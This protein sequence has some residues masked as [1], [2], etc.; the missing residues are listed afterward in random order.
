M[1]KTGDNQTGLRFGSGTSNCLPARFTP[2]LGAWEVPSTR[3][4]RNVPAPSFSK[5]GSMGLRTNFFSLNWECARGRA[6]AV[7]H[8]HRARFDAPSRMTGGYSSAA[9]GSINFAYNPLDEGD[10]HAQPF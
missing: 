10:A 6:E 5:S 8:R 4:R 7:F 9:G 2:N 3:M 1:K